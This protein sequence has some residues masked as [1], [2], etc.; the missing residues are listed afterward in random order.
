MTRLAPT[1]GNGSGSGPE[2]WAWIFTVPPSQ[3]IHI[4]IV[5]IDGR[6]AD[7]GEFA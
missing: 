4:I 5:V 1:C 6:A 7:C 2:S 3:Q